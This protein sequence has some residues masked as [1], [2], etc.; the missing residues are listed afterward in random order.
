M[1]INGLPQ[2]Q[3]R[4][5]LRKSVNNVH[6][7]ASGLATWLAQKSIG[8]TVSYSAVR[9]RDLLFLIVSV[10]S[11]SEQGFTECSSGCVLLVSQNADLFKSVNV[12]NAVMWPTRENVHR[13]GTIAISK[14]ATEHTSLCNHAKL[15]SMD[16]Y[17]NK[18][19]PV[20]LQAGMLK[21]MAA[22]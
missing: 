11:R 8:P 14:L 17:N 13:S 20:D 1:E 6:H 2:G 7:N 5:Q 3:L 18:N 10:H 22:V 16:L 15:T 4:M 19:Q 12:Q 21:L 9:E